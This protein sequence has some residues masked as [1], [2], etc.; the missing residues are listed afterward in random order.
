[1]EWEHK[2]ILNMLVTKDL[3][4]KVFDQIYRWGETLAYI[5][6]VIRDSYHHTIMSKLGQAVFGRYMIFNLTSVVEW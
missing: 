6:W 2:V 1:M 3:D 5:A 4:K